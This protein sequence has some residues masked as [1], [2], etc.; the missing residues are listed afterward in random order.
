MLLNADR[1]DPGGRRPARSSMLFSGLHAERLDG[2]QASLDRTRGRV[3][4]FV[5]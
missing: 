3:L 4:R 1:T 5:T 2:S